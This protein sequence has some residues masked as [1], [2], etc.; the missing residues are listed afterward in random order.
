MEAASREMCMFQM[1]NFEAPSGVG[2]RALLKAR[3]WSES[4]ERNVRPI[5]L[6]RIAVYAGLILAVIGVAYQARTVWMSVQPVEAAEPNRNLTPGATRAVTLQDICP[7]KNNE[8]LDP[9]VSPS[10]QREVFREY[11]IT[12]NRSGQLYQVDYLI[13]PQLGGTAEPRNLWPELSSTIAWNARAKD[14]LERRLHQMVC[15]QSIDLNVAQKEIATDWIAAYK[16]YFHTTRP[17]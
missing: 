16:K 11:G 10:I 9:Q 4:K 5:R 13:N 3:L 17:I 6:V 2:P 12:Q 1:D 8:D 15:S 7:S 14:A